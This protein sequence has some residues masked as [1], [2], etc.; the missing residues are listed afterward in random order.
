MAGDSHLRFEEIGAISKATLRPVPLVNLEV[1]AQLD[2]IL[3]LVDRLKG[4]IQAF[5][6]ETGT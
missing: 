4:E 1:K 3:L 6:M 2:R 5:E